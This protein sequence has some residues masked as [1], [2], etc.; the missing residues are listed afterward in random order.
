MTGNKA[1]LLTIG[2]D[3]YQ[4]LIAKLK[5]PTRNKLEIRR[6]KGIDMTKPTIVVLN[7]FSFKRMFCKDFT[8]L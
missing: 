4:M 6:L 2:L 7:N 3:L 5:E 1:I 8:G